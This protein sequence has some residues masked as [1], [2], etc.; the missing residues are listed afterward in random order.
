MVMIYAGV[1]VSGGHYDPAVTM[2]VLVRGR[3]A[4]G[5]AVGYW[6]AQLVAGLVAAVVVRGASRRRRSRP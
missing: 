5:E 6:I 4:L 3:I 1:H 2:A